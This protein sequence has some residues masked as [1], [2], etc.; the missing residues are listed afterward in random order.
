MTSL[1]RM[2]NC[3]FLARHGEHD[4]EEM[5][6]ERFCVDAGVLDHVEVTVAWSQ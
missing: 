6:G 2:E 4:E 1:I 5:L 3:A